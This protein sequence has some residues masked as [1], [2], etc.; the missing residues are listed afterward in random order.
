MA[1]T[2][3]KLQADR[4]AIFEKMDVTGAVVTAT[5]TSIPRGETSS[6]AAGDTFVAWRTNNLSFRL[7]REAGWVDQ[8]QGSVRAAYSD[9]SDLPDRSTV[10]VDG[11]ERRILRV[12]HGA[13]RTYSKLHLGG[14]EEAQ[15]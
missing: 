3:A 5:V 10:T 6:L 8:Y 15:A 13:T 4:T 2:T 11:T 1:L 14:I 12:E 7:I 9:V